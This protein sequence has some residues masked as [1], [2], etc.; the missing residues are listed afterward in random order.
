VALVP[1]KIGLIHIDMHPEGRQRTH[2]RRSS[3]RTPTGVSTAQKTAGSTQPARMAAVTGPSA[4][5]RVVSTMEWAKGSPSHVK[6]VRVCRP[7]VLTFA[8]PLSLM[9][10]GASPLWQIRGPYVSFAA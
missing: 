6:R 3:T 7:R 5:S 8:S 4:H 1:R 10:S 9:S 2:Q